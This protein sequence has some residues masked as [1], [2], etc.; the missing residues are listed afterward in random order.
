[1][2]DG[3][4]RDCPLTLAELARVQETFLGWLKARAHHRP[5]YPTASPYPAGTAPEGTAAQMSPLPA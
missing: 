5:A 1:V 3:T 2:A 4:M